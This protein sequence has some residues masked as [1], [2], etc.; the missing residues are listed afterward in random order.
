LEI[1]LNVIEHT[2]AKRVLAQLHKLGLLISDDVVHVLSLDRI[3][4]RVTYPSAF[5]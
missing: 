5:G 2:F 1:D 3:G 4:F